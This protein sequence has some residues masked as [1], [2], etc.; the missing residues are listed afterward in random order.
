[1]SKLMFVRLKEDNE[2]EGETWCFWLQRNGNEEA[3]AKL[4][5]LLDSDDALS[6]TFT[7]DLTIV[8]TEEEVDKLVEQAIKDYKE[9]GGYTYEHNKITGTFVWPAEK[10]SAEDWAQDLNKGSI[11]DFFKED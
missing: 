8:N 10:K 9:D 3:L 1:M 7:L 5:N 6:D 4:G 2:W 11:K